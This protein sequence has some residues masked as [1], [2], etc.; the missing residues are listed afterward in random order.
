[1]KLAEFLVEVATDPAGRQ[2]RSRTNTGAGPTTTA[3]MVHALADW[4]LSNNTVQ[5]TNV[6]NWRIS[7]PPAC[8]SLIFYYYFSFI[9]TPVVGA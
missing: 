8:S 5:K 2:S 6:M 1:M 7:I 3:E 4:R 9:I